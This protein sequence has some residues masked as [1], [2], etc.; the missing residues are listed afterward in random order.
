LI[1]F[2]LAVT[3]LANRIVNRYSIWTAVLL[4]LSA[5][6]L[7]CSGQGIGGGYVT[8]QQ[9]LASPEKYNGKNVTLE[10]FYFH[11]WEVSCLSET[12]GPSG[13]TE[14]HLVPKGELIWVEGGM[15]K[16]VYDGLYSQQMMGPT[17]RYGKVR[18]SGKL[19]YGG[20]YGHVGGYSYQITPTQVELLQ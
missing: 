7:S 3:L 15:P 16:E 11:G 9:L 13:Y 14:G 6:V 2:S 12:L 17:E 18:V 19:Q 8:F 20:R 1:H 4:I 10:G 5:S